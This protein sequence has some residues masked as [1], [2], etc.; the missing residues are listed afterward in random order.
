MTFISYAQNFED[1]LLWRALKHVANGFYIDVGANDPTTDSVTK[2]FYERGWRGINIEPLQSHYDDLLNDRPRDI[3]LK[4]AAGNITGEIEVWECDIRGWGTAAMDVVEQHVADGHAGKFH[5]VPVLKLSEI[6]SQHVSGQIH[7]L[8]IDVEGFEKSV[9]EGMDFSLF[10]PWILVIE[11][12]KPNSTEEIHEEWESD[13]LVAGY[14]FAYGDGLN[15]FYVAQEHSELLE[16]LRY[17]PNVFDG[18]IRSEQFNLQCR[19]EIAEAKASEAE[20]KVNEAEA[21]AYQAEVK[22][23]QA[24]AR[25]HQAETKINQ[26]EATIAAIHRSHSWRITAPL[27]AALI[28]LRKLKPSH[29][30]LYV[31]FKLRKAVKYTYKHPK[32]R[33]FTL[34]TLENFPHLKEIFIR[35]SIDTHISKP[36][37]T[38]RPITNATLHSRVFATVPTPPEA[39]LLPVAPESEER[40]VRLTGHIEGHYSL[41]IVNRGLA[42][43]LEKTTGSH[44]VFVPYHGQPYATPPNLPENQQKILG[45]T[46]GRIIPDALFHEVISLVHH[47]PFISDD[48][49][50]GLRFILFF[51]EETSVPAETIDHINNNFDGVLVAAQSVKRALI[52]SGCRPQVFVIPIG[53]D[54]LIPADV[55]ALDLAPPKDGGVIRFLHVSSAFERKGVDVLLAAYL[56]AFTANDPV[57]LYIKTY[58]NPH[59]QIHAQLQNLLVGL[60]SPPRVIIDEEQLDD[61]GMLELYRS[62][63]A[64]LLPTRGEG[65]NLPAAEALAMGLPVL[66]TGYSAQTDF[67]CHATATLLDFSFAGSRSHLRAPDACWLEPSREDLSAKLRVLRER[68]LGN[69]VRLDIQRKNGISLIRNTYTWLNSAKAVLNCAA[70]LTKQLHGKNQ[71]LNLA[72]ISPWACRCGIAEYSQHQLQALIDN[73]EIKL[74]VFCDDRTKY[75]TDVA[76]PGWTI[77]DS[78]SVL[79]ALANIRQTDHQV[80]LVQH[81]PS[82]FH[83]SDAICQEMLNLT[84]QGRVVVLELHSTL[85]LL[86]EIRLTNVALHALAKLD[87]IIVHKIED[88]N[89]L[90]A[91]GLADNVML[92][93]LG[94]ISPPLDSVNSQKRPLLNIPENALVL[95]CF[96]FALSH[97]GIDTLVESIKPLQSAIN[98]PVHLLAINSALDERSIQLIEQ[99]KTQAGLLGVEHQITWITEYKE[100]EEVQSLLCA[101]DYIVFPYKQTRES[102][103]GAVTIGLSTLKPVLV[104]PLDIFS[105][106]TDTTWRMEGTKAEDVVKAIVALSK[107]PDVRDELLQRQKKWLEVRDWKNISDRMLNIFNSLVRNRRLDDEISGPLKAFREEVNNRRC[108]QL[109]V[110]VSE[111]YYRDAR[112]GIQRVV[113]SLLNELFKDPPSGFVVCPV[114]GSKVDGFKYT[115]KFHPAGQFGQ[116]E[117]PVQVASGDVFL[118][119]D[120]AAHLFPEIEQDLSEFR[121]AGVDVYYVVYDI[122]P[123]KYPHFSIPDITNAFELWLSGIAKN[124]NG[125]ICISKSVAQDVKDWLNLSSTIFPL[126]AIDHFHLGADI[127]CSSPS[128]GL[129]ENAGILL[130][131][132]KEDT[133]FLMVGTIE[134]RKGH[135]HVL[136][137][138]E[139]LWAAGS[140]F[141]L[142]LVGKEGWGTDQLVDRIR[143]HPQHEKHLFWIENAS[144][145]YL[146]KIYSSADCL[147]VA[148]ECEG[149]G[150]PLI[151]AAHH[152]LPIIARDIPV[153][154]E[155]AG[156]SAHY[157][158]GDAPGDLASSIVVWNDLYAKNQH[159]KSTGINWLTWGQS[160]QNLLTCLN[161]PD[162]LP[163]SKK[164]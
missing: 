65:F 102:A 123:L 95:G 1:V 20:I 150:L 56:D 78:V 162:S 124:S 114:Y 29:L 94:V 57:E 41:S 122:I 75:E 116:N 7:F 68:I 43:A 121:L 111:M 71:S 2:A 142:L 164:H 26:A 103:S 149:F 63:H 136:N 109:L 146:E 89:N 40:W 113:R 32:L 27:R 69:D 87:R 155:I 131:K 115:N 112:T 16:T 158:S 108:K 128:C 96:G 52:N 3:N 28:F 163:D 55:P 151:E 129:P 120:L 134:P 133:I 90:L 126:P 10:R 130:S 127:S 60:K 88:L 38:Y 79:K 42:E 110:D 85:P 18:F 36:P 132:L 117:Q 83:L 25:A 30:K 105:D 104:S 21:K 66:T 145:E 81:Q 144:D 138:F 50:A 82:L 17:P 22:T 118:G 119:L 67:C 11:A 53:V 14:K 62:S 48:L 160:K 15:R 100:I 58:P 92:L 135:Q 61:A 45:P 37:L 139:A 59:N 13:I 19:L 101:A 23:R 4:C 5:K 148:S 51:W 98:A 54:H 161:L 8:K 47:Y 34:A 70:W 44:L 157:F 72:V 84:K 49:P 143:S 141:R 76:V 35:L 159:P 106:V 24:E 107:R 31:Q 9:I 140:T 6:C 137:A 152:E 80:I 74:T 39:M 97:K 86:D 125:L 64:M 12:T 99:Y 156:N 77:G 33:D 154:K 46:L 93:N 73:P 91:L 153:F 147:I